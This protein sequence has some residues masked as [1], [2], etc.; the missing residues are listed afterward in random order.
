MK[1]AIFSNH[2]P[3]VGFGVDRKMDVSRSQVMVVAASRNHLYRRR[4]QV[5]IDAGPRNHLYLLGQ[6]VKIRS[7]PRNQLHGG[8]AA[9]SVQLTV[10]GE[11]PEARPAG[12]AER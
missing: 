8:Q 11:V 1:A 5:V 3:R 6:Q 4:L 9:K 7:S 2:S 10:F 12:F